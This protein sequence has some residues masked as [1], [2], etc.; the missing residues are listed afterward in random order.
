M[1]DIDE[2]CSRIKSVFNLDEVPEITEKNLKHYLE[3]LKLKFTCPCTLTGIESMGYFSWEEKY[4]FGYGNPQRYMK[5]KKERGS[6]KEYY[7]LQDF[8]NAKVKEDCDILVVV[9]RVSDRKR[10]IIPLSELKV[11]DENSDN[12][13]LLNDYTVWFVNWS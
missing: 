6:Y 12:Y 8:D 13:Q 1:N 4:D 7:E 11:V 2:K 3:W 10:F 5:M 9:F